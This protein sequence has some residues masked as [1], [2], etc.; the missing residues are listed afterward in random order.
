MRTQLT[1]FILVGAMAFNIGKAATVCTP[2]TSS[3]NEIE[4]KVHLFILSGQSNMVGIDPEES[5]EPSVK[6]AF[7]E[8]EV[9]IVKDAHSGQPI[10]RWY[11]NWKPA[12][13]NQPKATGDLYERLMAKVKTNIAE[14]RPDS[15]T[16]VWMQGER[17][18]R[19]KHGEVYAA[20]LTG[21]I[22]QVREDLE[23]EDINFII[24][25][26]S[27]F[28][29]ADKVYP[30]WTKVRKAQTEVSKADYRVAWINTDDLNG[31]EN[32]LHYTKDGYIKLGNR[33]AEKAIELIIKNK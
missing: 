1:Y 33:F 5:F 21:L 26:L 27:D 3:E 12:T 6:K 25:R 17:D 15:V 13:G 29:N 9:I 11:K 16:F 32:D 18:A 30:H 8:D 22:N 10:R 19:E 24:G 7:P 20:G 14:K 31:P 4:E 28:D 23:R 2:T